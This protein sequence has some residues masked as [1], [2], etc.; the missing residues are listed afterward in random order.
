MVLIFKKS[1]LRNKSLLTALLSVACWGNKV[2]NTVNLILIIK[3]HVFNRR[4]KFTLMIIS[5]VF[6]TCCDFTCYN[7]SLPVHLLVQ[8]IIKQ[9]P[10]EVSTQQQ[11]VSTVTSQQQPAATA[12]HQFV[13]VKGGHMISMSA[14]KQA[15]GATGATTSKVSLSYIYPHT[16]TKKHIN[17]CVV[18]IYSHSKTN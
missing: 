1:V 8:V 15:G 7:P 14:Q 3:L 4:V 2:K 18:K 10:G 13:A 9:E 11:M 12:A 6:P 16:V 17:Q 5:A